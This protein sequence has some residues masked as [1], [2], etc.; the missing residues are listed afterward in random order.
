MARRVNLIHWFLLALL[1]LALLFIGCSIGVDN[2]FSVANMRGLALAATTS[3]GTI[4]I[5]GHDDMTTGFVGSAAT[6][7]WLIQLSGPWKTT[8]SPGSGSVKS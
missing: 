7:S 1:V 6:K 8:T 4:V 2:F 3:T 5:H